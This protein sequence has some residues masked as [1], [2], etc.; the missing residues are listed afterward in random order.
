MQLQTNL[1]HSRCERIPHAAGLLLTATVNHLSTAFTAGG[2]TSRT[3][4]GSTA[5]TDS[6]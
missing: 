4:Y 6:P 3:T 2:S 1:C 5:C